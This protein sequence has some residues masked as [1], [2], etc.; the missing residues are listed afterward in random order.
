MASHSDDISLRR[1]EPTSTARARAFN[2]EAVNAFFDLQKTVQDMKRFTPDR[3]YNV[4]ET[5]ITI[6]PNRP[7]KIIASRG[8]ETGWFTVVCCEGTTCHGRNLRAAGSFILVFQEDEMRGDG[9]R[10]PASIAI[11]LERGWMQSHIF[12]MW[13]EHFLKHVNPP[14]AR[15]VL[16]ISDGHKTHTNNLPFIEM[17]RA[18]FVTVICLPAISCSHSMSAS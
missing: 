17:A 9:P 14:E 2:Q 3:V 11:A 8:K 5:G 7:S 16:L 1:S 13:F 4:D 12:V 10:T 6:V 15:P 18:N